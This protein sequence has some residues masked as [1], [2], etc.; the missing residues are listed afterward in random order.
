MVEESFGYRLL[1]DKNLLKSFS[2]QIKKHH[3]SAHAGK[4]EIEEIVERLSPRRKVFVHGYPNSL[5]EH[6]LNREVIRF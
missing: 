3:F 6:G 4:E 2:C 1:H 5:K